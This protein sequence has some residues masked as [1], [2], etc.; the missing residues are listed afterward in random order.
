NGA[1]DGVRSLVRFAAWA[2]TNYAVAVDGVNAAQG[3][4]DLNWKLG[5]PPVTSYVYSNQTIPKGGSTLLSVSAISPTPDL[6]YQWLLDGKRITGA[7]NATL[8]LT[9]LQPS[10]SGA[11]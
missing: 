6:T 8:T 9:N 11:Y 10:Q 1:P 4:I 5:L 7:T 2:G 3:L